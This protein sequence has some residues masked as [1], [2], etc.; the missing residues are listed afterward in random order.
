MLLF[1]ER[2]YFADML[3]LYFLRNDMNMAKWMLLYGKIEI[4][5]ST[6]ILIKP[7]FQHLDINFQF[8]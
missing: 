6:T 4:N 2:C 5:L 7:L 8:F 3:L 1:N